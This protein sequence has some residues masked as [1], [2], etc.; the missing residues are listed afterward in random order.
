MLFLIRE[1]LIINWGKGNISVFKAEKKD[2]N[3]IIQMKTENDENKNSSEE[4]LIFQPI[5]CRDFLHCE[6]CA[7]EN[8]RLEKEFNKMKKTF[9]KSSKKAN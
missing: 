8:Y 3:T 7:E 6:Y 4:E 9:L 1:T 5:Q 2:L